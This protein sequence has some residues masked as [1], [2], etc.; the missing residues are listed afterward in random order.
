[1]EGRPGSFTGS[2]FRYD[3]MYIPHTL[4]AV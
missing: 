4:A 1:L 3:P 2:S